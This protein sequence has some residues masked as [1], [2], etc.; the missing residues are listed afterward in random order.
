MKLFSLEEANELLPSVRR[1]VTAMQKLHRRLLASQDAARYAA[2]GANL[3]GGGMADG[4]IYVQVVSSF[5]ELVG[6]IEEIGVQ[7]K[8][9]SRGLIDF[10]SLRDEQIVLLCWQIGEGD[11]IEWWHDLESGFGGRQKI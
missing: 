11:Q 1:K 9:Y 4:P 10:P 3:G 6:E 8:D 7:I 5:L 2:E